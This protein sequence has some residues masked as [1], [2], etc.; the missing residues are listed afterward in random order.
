MP[1]ELQINIRLEDEDLSLLEK[2]AATTVRTKSD[3]VRFLIRQ[4]WSRMT[5]ENP[6]SAKVSQPAGSASLAS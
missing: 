5:G 6:L 1:K 3:M 4:E 2:M